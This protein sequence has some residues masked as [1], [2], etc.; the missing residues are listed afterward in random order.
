MKQH[1]FRNIA[2]WYNEKPQW[3]CRILALVGGDLPAWNVLVGLGKVPECAKQTQD[4]PPL[5]Y[6]FHALPSR[7]PQGRGGLTTWKLIR[8]TSQ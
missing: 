4:L 1:M 8:R 3:T 5:K 6:D 7:C 2:I